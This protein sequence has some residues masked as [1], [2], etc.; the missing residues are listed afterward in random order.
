MAVNPKEYVELFEDKNLNKKH[1]GIQ[2]GSSGIGFENFSQRIKSLV[3]F[4]TSEKATC[5]TKN[6]SRLTVLAGEMVKA[7]VIKNKF[8]Q[9]N[10]KRFYFPVGIVSLPFHHPVLAEINEFK[11]KKG[12]RT[13][14]YFWKEKEHLLNLEKQALKN[15][16][17]L[18][19]Y[20][21]I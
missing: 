11:Q 20:H 18:Y 12:Q 17:R 1:K 4:D 15:H 5:D 6:V 21:Q 7:S 8:S 2:K 13:K 9:L 16:P 10:N 14:N 3:N 19:L